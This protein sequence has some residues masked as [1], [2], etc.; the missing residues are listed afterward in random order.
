MG[1]WSQE[2]EYLVSGSD[3]HRLFIWSAYDKFSVRKVLDTGNPVVIVLIQ[4]TWE[5][6]SRQS[7]CRI[8]IIRKL[9]RVREIDLSSCPR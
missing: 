2:G 7:S 5:I 1:S 3:D 4:V 8:R 9:Y 6:Y